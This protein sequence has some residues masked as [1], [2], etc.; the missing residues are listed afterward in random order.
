MGSTGDLPLR[1]LRSSRLLHDQ[2]MAGGDTGRFACGPL[3]RRRKG[4][5]ERVKQLILDLIP[6]S[7]PTL[8]NFVPGRNGEALKALLDAAS[9]VVDAYIF[10]ILG[11]V[12][13]GKSRQIFVRNGARACAAVPTMVTVNYKVS[14]IQGRPS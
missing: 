11:G 7:A 9:E 4:I 6:A 14:S 12:S 1:I 3:E 5:I 13:S 2:E 8:D 10:Y